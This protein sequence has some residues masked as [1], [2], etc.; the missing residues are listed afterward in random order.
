MANA[1]FFGQSNGR[2]CTQ[3]SMRER[4]VMYVMVVH[5]K[6]GTGESFDVC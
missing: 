1:V 3:K 6:C 2:C 5:C 4:W